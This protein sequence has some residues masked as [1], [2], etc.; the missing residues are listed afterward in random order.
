MSMVSMM[1]GQCG[2]QIGAAAYEALHAERPLPGDR[3]LFDEGGHARA[4]LVDGEAKVVGALVRHADG[5]FS[6][7]NAFVEDSGRGNNW[8]L[9][10]YGP[11]AGNPPPLAPLPVAARQLDGGEALES[12]LST[13]VLSCNSYVE[14]H[15]TFECLLLPLCP[16]WQR[17][18]EG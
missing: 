8:A 4:V 6:R 16:L 1:V 3:A 14:R 7:A 10:Y 5:P 11:R 15:L 2:N 18:A 12:Q 9:G 13:Q 17:K